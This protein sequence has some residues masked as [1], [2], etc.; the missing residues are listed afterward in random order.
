MIC[1][2]A[3]QSVRSS[4]EVH[5]EQHNR[6]VGWAADAVAENGGRYRRE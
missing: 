5:V 4:T 2:H 1:T 6:G 3:S